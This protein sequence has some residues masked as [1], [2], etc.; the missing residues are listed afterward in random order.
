MKDH[1]ATLGVRRA[2]SQTEIKKAYR[3]L[4]ARYHPDKHRG[5]ELEDLAREKLTELNEAYAVLSDPNKRAAYDASPGGGIPRSQPAGPGPAPQADP[6]AIIR[7]LVRLIMMLS[8]V[9]FTFRFIRSPRAIAVIAAA[10]LIAW[11]GP[12]LLR[13]FKSKK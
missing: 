7:S 12:R 10:I 4:A 5:N 8:I 6:A 1:Y 3:A 2:A 13:R 11:F 9:F